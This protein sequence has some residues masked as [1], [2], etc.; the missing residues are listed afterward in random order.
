MPTEVADHS[1]RAPP[2]IQS[3]GWSLLTILL[4]PVHA[5]MIES[6]L[7]AMLRQSGHQHD[8][9]MSGAQRHWHQSKSAEQSRHSRQEGLRKTRARSSDDLIRTKQNRLRNSDAERFRG[10]EIHYQFELSVLLNVEIAWFGTCQNLVNIGCDH[11]SCR[12]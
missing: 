9:Q 6:S 8:A 3:P 7:A 12:C 10:F 11:A 4:S 5:E 2:S 1:P